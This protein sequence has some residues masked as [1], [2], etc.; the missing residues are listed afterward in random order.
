MVSQTISQ[1]TNVGGFVPNY[2]LTRDGIK[3]ADDHPALPPDPE[4]LQRME[5]RLRASQ[6]MTPSEQH[7]LE[8]A[9][10]D[11]YSPD[12]PEG[13]DPPEIKVVQNNVILTLHSRALAMKAERIIQL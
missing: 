1:L 7:N 11:G 8:S 3:F 4:V 12:H 10:K 2:F 13:Q 9:R 6:I 5:D